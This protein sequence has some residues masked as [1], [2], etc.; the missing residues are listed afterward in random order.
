MQ[1]RLAL[2]LEY[3]ALSSAPQEAI[4]LRELYKDLNSKLTTP[5]IIFEDNQAAIK[6]AKNPQYHGRSRHI[7][8]KHHFIR[9]Q[10]SSN[11][12]E[13]RYCRT[14]NMIADIFT[15][16]LSTSKSVKLQDMIRIDDLSVCE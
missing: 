8:I 12:I 7:C 3:M 2:L 5:T 14:Y 1:R 6:M 11:I 15:K 4:W 9:E 16:G 10:V 13:L